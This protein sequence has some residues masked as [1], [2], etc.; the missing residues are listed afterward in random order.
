[1]N[2]DLEHRRLHQLADRLESRL[3]TVQVLAEVILD[4]A[5]MREGIP[6]PYLDDVREAA[7]M[8]AV[9]HLSRSN[10]EDFQHVAK[11][12]QLPLR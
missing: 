3:N 7:L 8:E 10:Q 9:I 2:S 5:A 1:M 6:G 4:N 11:L 12:A